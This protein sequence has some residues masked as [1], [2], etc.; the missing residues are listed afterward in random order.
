MELDKN[1]PI[2]K[3]SWKTRFFGESSRRIVGVLRPRQGIPDGKLRRCLRRPGPGGFLSRLLWIGP[4]DIDLG[5]FFLKVSG[6]DFANLIEHW[7]PL[8]TT[9]HVLV[10]ITVPRT[11]AIGIAWSL[12]PKAARTAGVAWAVHYQPRELMLFQ[13]PANVVSLSNYP[14]WVKI[15]SPSLMRN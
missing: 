9:C 12:E 3:S 13:I 11:S 5:V 1:W 2:G 4:L 7:S 15:N 6:Q 10:T 14:S 8:I